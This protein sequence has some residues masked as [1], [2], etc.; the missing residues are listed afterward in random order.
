MKTDKQDRDWTGYMVFIPD[1]HSLIITGPWKKERPDMWWWKCNSCT[2]SSGVMS[3]IELIK[4]DI[5]GM[6]VTPEDD[7]KLPSEN[8]RHPKEQNWSEVEHYGYG[9]FGGWD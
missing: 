7:I 9:W 6:I 2:E 4:L 1:Q 5:K 3:T 8:S